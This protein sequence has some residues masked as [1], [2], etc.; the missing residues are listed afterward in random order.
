M[1]RVKSLTSPAPGSSQKP[2]GGGDS[3]QSLGSGRCFLVHNESAP[4]G[5]PEE[6]NVRTPTGTNNNSY[7]TF[8][9]EKTCGNCQPLFKMVTRLLARIDSLNEALKNE[10][11]ARLSLIK[12]YPNEPCLNLNI[13]IANGQTLQATKKGFLEAK[14]NKENITV[15]A[16]IVPGLS[17]NLMSVSQLVGRGM[18]IT[19]KKGK[20]IIK[21]GNK[22]YLGAKQGQLYTFE[23]KLRN[24]EENCKLTKEENANIWHQRLG[25]I[26]VRFDESNVRYEEM[27]E[28]TSNE[29]NR[30]VEII[31]QYNKKEMKVEKNNTTVHQEEEEEEDE[32]TSYEPTLSN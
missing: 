26:Y 2:P 10:C 1:N 18:E 12:V 7:L 25:H 4:S 22:T 15:E 16:V 30:L 14:Y 9:E 32:S 13:K 24:Q 11:N 21:S 23:V 31:D 17:T 29:P 8:S 6:G 27:T 5:D 19:F 20:L 3:S 28:S